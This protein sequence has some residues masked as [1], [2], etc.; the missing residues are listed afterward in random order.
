MRLVCGY[1]EL[2]KAVELLSG[3]P[4]A[5]VSNYPCVVSVDAGTVTLSR[6]SMN[7]CIGVQLNG[8]TRCVDGRVAVDA[9]TL[10]KMLAV[11]KPGAKEPQDVILSV[12][13]SAGETLEDLL[14]VP[15]A[16]APGPMAN[17]L[18]FRSGAGFK[19]E[20]PMVSADEVYTPTQP[21]SWGRLR[22]G[23]LQDIIRRVGYCT[24]TKANSN[25]QQWWIDKLRVTVDDKGK[26]RAEMTDGHRAVVAVFDEPEETD[27]ASD[28]AFTHGTAVDVTL[29]KWAANAVGSK[30][31]FLFSVSD[32]WMWIKTADTA[33]A[34]Y[35]D[36]TTTYPD[37][38]RVFPK[39]YKGGCVLP[40]RMLRVVLARADSTDADAVDFD[41]AEG[42]SVFVKATG[43][44][45]NSMFSEEVDGA[46]LTGAFSVRMSVPYIKQA[47]AGLNMGADDKIRLGWAS[48][49][50]PFGI[51]ADQPGNAGDRSIVMPTRR[52]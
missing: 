49:T 10:G 3:L 31:S 26:I 9:S 2:S 24:A 34:V 23:L 19:A 22:A 17:A 38:S 32:Q 30:D 39:A 16:N 37:F 27:P 7:G 48:D 44:E 35:V 5:G 52:D 1:K 6:S 50:A 11:A 36:T 43:R 14:F 21:N 40:C 46:V 20:L 8:G 12:R 29:L 25:T 42:G 41:A 18:L 15:A 47:V 13:E 45:R 33:V 51:D 28:A 4:T